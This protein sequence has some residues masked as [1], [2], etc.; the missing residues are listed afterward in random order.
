MPVE[1]TQD[2]RVI[3]SG[4]DGVG[5]Y[6]LITLRAA[7]KLQVETG[8]KMSRVSAV[9]CAKRLGYEGR[10]AKALLQD[11]EKKHPELAEAERA[12]GRSI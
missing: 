12:T 6:R 10:T 5:L 9:A 2:G 7:L 8:I 4:Q 1:V 11:I 3:Y